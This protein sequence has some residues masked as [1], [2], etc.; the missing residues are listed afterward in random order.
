M[1][2]ICTRKCCVN[3]EDI[4]AEKG[5]QIIEET[6]GFIFPA[7][8]LILNVCDFLPVLKWFRYKGYD[9]FRHK[10]ESL[11]VSKSSTSRNSDTL[12]E[13]LLSLQE[14]EPEF[15]TND[16]IKNVLLTLTSLST[17]Y[18]PVMY[19]RL[20]CRNLLIVTSPSAVEECFTKNDIIFANRPQTMTADKYSFNYKAVVWAPYGYHWRALRRLMVIEIFSFNSLQKS[21][22]LRS[23]EIRILIRGLF[24]V[25]C[26]R[27]GSSGVKINLS[28]WVF[29]FSFNVMMRIGTGKRCVSEEEI[30]TEKGKEII[31]E[32]KGFFFATLLVLN[33]CDFLPV[34]KWF[35]YKGIEKRMVSAHKKRNEFLNSLFD[36]FRQKK[37]SPISVS[38]SSTDGNREKKGTLVETLLSLQESEPEFYTDDLIKSVV[39]ILFIAGTETTSMTIQW[40]MRLLLA[41]PEAFHKLRAEIDSK[42]GNERLLNES[43]F[44]NLP[45]LQCV[46]NETLRLY[47]PVPLL[48]PHYSLED[49]TIGGYDVPKHTI[50]MVNAWAIHRD[51]EVWEEPEKFKPERFEGMEGEKE[52]FNYKF[53]SFGMGRR[54][55]PGAAMGLRTVS[56][57]LGSLIQWFDWENVEFEENLDACYNTR[58]T[59]NKEKPLE[60]ICIP[61]QNCIRFLDQL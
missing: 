31:E 18:G 30:G 25:N 49:C 9:E 26:N 16:L 20:G 6:R 41:H 22:A 3:E 57:V 40:A 53:V 56:L 45:Y 38:E 42:V 2:R 19:L 5:K 44:T 13:T 21:S 46:I 17:K 27:S 28:N 10:K 32:I 48:L 34:L 55:C 36:E 33:V 54:A 61:R 51:P 14:S 12:V 37:V 39:L 24:K 43:D 4:G 52:G 7:F 8:A 58:I 60:A 50:L 15:Y 29:T 23:E 47:P 59:L 35:G 1:M 11:S